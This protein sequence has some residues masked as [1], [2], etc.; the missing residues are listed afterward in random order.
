MA[1]WRHEQLLRQDRRRKKL[2]KKYSWTF[3][4]FWISPVAG[5]SLV[6]L[7]DEIGVQDVLQSFCQGS[8]NNR[9]H[10]ANIIEV[11]RPF[12]LHKCLNMCLYCSYLTVIAQGKCELRS[13]WSLS[14]YSSFRWYMG[15]WP[16]LGT[17]CKYLRASSQLVCVFIQR[18]DY[19]YAGEG[20]FKAPYKCVVTCIAGTGDSDRCWW[21]MPKMSL[22]GIWRWFFP[23]LLGGQNLLWVTTWWCCNCHPWKDTE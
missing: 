14:M 9:K 15:F 13:L 17:P 19:Y 7:A 12:T 18:D 1:V 2:K 20:V 8:A 10:N 11:I 23:F 5:C 22:G 4:H 21:H 16:S 3:K 6:E